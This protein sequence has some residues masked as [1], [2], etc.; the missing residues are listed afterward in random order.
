MDDFLEQAREKSKEFYLKRAQAAALS[1]QSSAQQAQQAVNEI[2]KRLM[3]Y[4]ADKSEENRNA[5]VLAAQGAAKI[6]REVAQL[7][8]EASEAALLI[9]SADLKRYKCGGQVKNEK[10]GM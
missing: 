2:A 6:A 3:E 7:A 1:A 5:V 8:N 10:R 4:E 9:V